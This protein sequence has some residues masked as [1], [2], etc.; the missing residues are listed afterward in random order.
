MSTT[1]ELIEEYRKKKEKIMSMG[2][3]E[4]IEKRHKGGQRE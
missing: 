1:E 3:L 2:G 4:A